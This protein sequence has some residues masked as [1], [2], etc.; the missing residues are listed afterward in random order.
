V[1]Q[2]EV[3][4]AENSV[5]VC[6]CRVR[7]RKVD[8]FGTITWA[9]GGA[10]FVACCIMVGLPLWTTCTAQI[11]GITYTWEVGVF[12]H[13]TTIAGTNL[14]EPANYEFRQCDASAWCSALALAM[15][16]VPRG[17]RRRR[18]LSSVPSL[19]MPPPP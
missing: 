19:H 17:R 16:S 9:M 5:K 11:V 4:T 18:A 12:Y 3:L 10:S 13:C 1:K 2:R 15:A 6:C 7:K 8:F 14:Q